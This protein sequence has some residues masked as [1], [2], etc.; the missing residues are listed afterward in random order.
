MPY[1][2][3]FLRGLNFANVNYKIFLVDQFL[4]TANSNAFP[5]DLILR[6][7]ILFS[8]PNKR[9]KTSFYC[10]LPL[11]VI[12]P[13]LHTHRYMKCLFTKHTE[14]IEYVKE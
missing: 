11:G 5:V 9:K 10:L 14:T 4:R 3:Q 12:M 6:I 7:H 2:D 1:M 8:G 13:N